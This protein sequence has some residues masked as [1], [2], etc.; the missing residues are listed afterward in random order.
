MLAGT[1]KRT[2]IP[3]ADRAILN[4]HSVRLIYKS[5]FIDDFDGTDGL[6]KFPSGELLPFNK[7]Q[8]VNCG[9][10]PVIGAAARILLLELPEG[11]EIVTVNVV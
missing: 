6:I 8:Y 1:S 4:E 2:W 7:D 5:G 9:G 11:S 3:I 10:T